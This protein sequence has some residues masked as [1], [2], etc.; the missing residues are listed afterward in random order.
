MPY[1]TLQEACRRLDRSEKTLRRWI[2]TGK[3][4]YRMEEG[5]F[6]LSVDDIEALRQPVVSESYILLSKR[7][8]GLESRL[9][10]IEQRLDGFASL[11]T[12]PQPS[13]DMAIAQNSSETVENAPEIE[14][15]ELGIITRLD[16]LATFMA[17]IEGKLEGLTVPASPK[18]ETPP[19][20]EHKPAASTVPRR[21]IPA[22]PSSP[23]RVTLSQ[24]ETASKPAA[25]SADVPPGS[26]LMREFARRHSPPSR[27]WYQLRIERG[28]IQAIE[29]SYHGKP[30][31]WFTR[32]QQ[33]AVLAYIREK[34]I[35]FRQCDDP[36]CACRG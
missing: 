8:E 19:Q 32:E 36:G 17:T 9:D 12:T 14:N 24:V 29:G 13:K 7:I 16:T 11:V 23:R 2:H 21:V 15:R 3:L 27:D 35:S 18:Q 28:E 33:K 31:Y 26:L 22:R 25:T 5:R 6:M 20:V 4:T 1:I 34:G 10:V 30:Q